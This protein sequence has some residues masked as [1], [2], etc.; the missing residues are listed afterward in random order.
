MIVT[1][2]V[3][4]TF[5]TIPPITKP[6]NDKVSFGLAAVSNTNMDDAYIREGYDMAY[7]YYPAWK[8][9]E[10][11][12]SLDAHR[13]RKYLI[14]FKGNVY[15]WEMRSWQHRWIAAEYWSEDPDVH[16]D[17]KCEGSSGA[18]LDYENTDP[19]DYGRALLDS[20]FIFCPGGGGVMSYRFA[21]SL[22]VGSIPVVTSDFL[23]PF[24]PELD[25]RGCVVQV[26]DARV[27][28][29]PRMVREMS[30][31]EVRERRRRC[32]DLTYLVYGNPSGNVTS[33]IA[34]RMFSVGMRVWN[35]RIKSALKRR[36]EVENMIKSSRPHSLQN[37]D[38]VLPEIR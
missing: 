26:S 3:L 1:H 13:P 20:T 32:A 22:L 10:D 17:A 21:E 28:D 12:D 37:V 23:P 9:P 24:H 18:T 38:E 27:V 5:S 16:V 30:A 36:E 29:V 2:A 34:K 6:F 33:Y 11:Y 31:D 15:P 8:R 4:L 19:D 35:V 7:S 14:S 25:W